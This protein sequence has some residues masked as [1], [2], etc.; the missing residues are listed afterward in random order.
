MHGLEVCRLALLS[1]I[2]IFLVFN[3]SATIYTL[4]SSRLLH[5]QL[6]VHVPTLL[7]GLISMPLFDLTRPLAE[8]LTK[9]AALHHLTP[10]C[11]GRRGPYQVQTSEKK[12]LPFFYWVGASIR[13]FDCVSGPIINYT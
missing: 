9:L 12:V 11:G 4:C 10:L 5:S 6:V 1:A 13:H 7:L 3:Y 2:K 8:T